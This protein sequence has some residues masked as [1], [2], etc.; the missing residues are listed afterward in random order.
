MPITQ[1]NS[2]LLLLADAVRATVEAEVMI[3]LTVTAIGIALAVAVLVF[4]L[5]KARGTTLRAPLMWAIVS[6]T[7][8]IA[9]EATQLRYRGSEAVRAKWDFIGATSTFCP[10]IALLGA[11]RPQNRAWQWIVLT[12]WGIVALPA[13]ES[14]VIHPNDPLELHSVWQVFVG[15]LVLV[16]CINYLP[17]CYAI[18]SLMVAASQCVLFGTLLFGPDSWLVS[19]RLKVFSIL[20]VLAADGNI[21]GLR[22]WFIIAGILPLAAGVCVAYLLGVRRHRLAFVPLANW[23]LVWRDFRNGFGLVWG[24]RVIERFN[25]MAD[26]TDISIRLTWPGFQRA[27]SKT[28]DDVAAQK[29]VGSPTDSEHWTNSLGPLEAGF[30]NLLWRFVSDEWIESRLRSGAFKQAIT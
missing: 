28:E 30:R 2:S 16:G 9:I 26:D 3:A 19:L 10:I 6:L 20:P 21:P 18:P 23:N 12:L 8:L 11:K 17:T 15:L 14:L 13:V 29:A 22:M 24:A 1:I 5:R 25:T 4:A 7:S 27:P